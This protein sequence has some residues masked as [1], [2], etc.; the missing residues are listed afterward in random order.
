MRRAD[1]GPRKGDA[2][3]AESARKH[4]CGL[5]LFRADLCNRRHQWYCSAPACRAASKARWLLHRRTQTVSAPTTVARV[6]FPT[7]PTFARRGKELHG[8]F[9]YFPG[10]LLRSAA[11][12]EKRPFGLARPVSRLLAWYLIAVL[13]ELFTE[14]RKLLATCGILV[15]LTARQP[16]L[17]CVSRRRGNLRRRE[18][19]RCESGTG[20]PSKQC[21]PLWLQRIPSAVHGAPPQIELRDLCDLSSLCVRITGCH[22]CLFQPARMVFGPG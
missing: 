8:V 6:N 9:Q 14:R 3:A 20:R 5:K 13:L 19:R 7:A 1:D 11:V 10:H 15:T 18:H 21:P 4:T 2:M 17:P 22:G 16:G 12:L